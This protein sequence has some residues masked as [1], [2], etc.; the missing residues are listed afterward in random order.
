MD[1]LHSVL[2][3]R[4]PN[5]LPYPEQYK[6]PIRDHLAELQKVFPTLAIRTG[7][8]HTNDGRNLNLLKAEGTIPIH[9]QGAKYNIPIV[10]WLHEAYPNAA[11]MV[12][13]VPTQNMVIKGS[14]PYVDRSGQ[15]STPC[16]RSWTI[17]R[18][19]LVEMTLEMSHLFGSDP[20]LYSQP[21]GAS[22]GSAGGASGQ[23]G[24]PS[25][26]AQ[27]TVQPP[28]AYPNYGQPMRP[29]PPPGVQPSPSMQYPGQS[30]YFGQN[31]YPGNPSSPT[32]NL[33]SNPIWGAAFMAAAGGQQS[34][35]GAGGASSGGSGTIPNYAAPQGGQGPSGSVIPNYGGIPEPSKPQP[36]SA[37]KE[38]VEADFRRHAI[39]GLHR[40]LNAA[41]RA[42]QKRCMEETDSLLDTQRKLTQRKAQLTGMV[43]ALKQERAGTEGIVKEMGRKT[44]QLQQ[45]LERNEPKLL[46]LGDRELDVQKCVV[47]ADELS[48]QA[49]DTQAE[50]LAIEDTILALDKALQAGLEGLSVEL[51]LKQVRA[52]C[53]K[54]FFARALGIAVAQAQAARPPV[55]RTSGVSA[56]YPIAHGDSWATPTPD[57]LPPP[58]PPPP[59]GR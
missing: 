33:A 28:P 30:N 14:H 38:E 48:K 22:A 31:S 50:D 2:Y 8:F 34:Q 45:W 3:Q 52:L 13:V 32:S 12:Y 1:Y 49:L 39:D 36:V 17:T 18:S 16:I 27:P 29:P 53:R 19:N 58:P 5:S 24:R 40:Q 51:Y 7:E 42:Y 47:P 6:W 15:V 56:A 9:F 46:A 10:V 35:G 37:R 26:Q 4:G 57:M 21:A 25:A 54:Q 59:P 43:N 41:E 23:Y 55:T 11:P 44:A 20:P